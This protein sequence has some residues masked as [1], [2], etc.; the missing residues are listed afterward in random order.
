M[1]THPVPRI[2]VITLTRTCERFANGADALVGALETMM[3]SG[4]P[5]LE[6][7]KDTILRT[8]VSSG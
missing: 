7:V 5:G 3:G 8:W 2:H 6:H 4:A 1:P